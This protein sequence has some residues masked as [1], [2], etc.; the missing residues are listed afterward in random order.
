[1]HASKPPAIDDILSKTGDDEGF[2][3]EPSAPGRK[4]GS[5]LP[6]KASGKATARNLQAWRAIEDMRDKRRLDGKLKEVYEEE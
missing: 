3:Y 2:D 6:S 5:K 4:P 1:M